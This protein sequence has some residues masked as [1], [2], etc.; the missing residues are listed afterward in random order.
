[1]GILHG[2]RKGVQKT[3]GRF[4]SGSAVG[5]GPLMSNTREQFPPEEFEHQEF[6]VDES[7]GDEH[8][9]SDAPSL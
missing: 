2:I 1:V 5:V 7:V 8:E 6:S 4:Y 3:F 9:E